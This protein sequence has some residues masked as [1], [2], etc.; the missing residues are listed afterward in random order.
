MTKAT[1]LVSVGSRVFHIILVIANID[2]SVLIVYTPSPSLGA[3]FLVTEIIS[4]CIYCSYFVIG[5]N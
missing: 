1:W 5:T 4:L 2:C 3:C